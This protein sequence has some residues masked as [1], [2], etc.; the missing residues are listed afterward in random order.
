MASVRGV[1]SR[2]PPTWA[3]RETCSLYVAS[4]TAA[5]ANDTVYTGNSPSSSWKLVAGWSGLGGVE[6][7][8]V[9]SILVLP[10]F[11]AMPAATSAPPTWTPAGCRPASAAGRSTPASGPCASPTAPTGSTWTGCTPAATTPRPEHGHGSVLTAATAVLTGSPGPRDGGGRSDPA[12]CGDGQRP[13]GVRAPGGAVRERRRRPPHPR[14]GVRPRARRGPDRGRRQRRRP[15]LRR[16]R[17]GGRRPGHHQERR[18]AVLG[19]DGRGRGVP[20]PGGG[21]HQ[22]R[23]PPGRPPQGPG[24]LAG[25]PG[26]AGGHRGGQRHRAVRADHRL[27]GHGRGRRRGHRRRAGARAGGRQPGPPDRLGVPLRPHSAGDPGVSRLRPLLAVGHRR[28]PRGTTFGSRAR[29]V[30]RQD[31]HPAAVDRAAGGRRGAARVA[32]GGR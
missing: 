18:A 8:S 25:D 9:V 5:T 32:A 29:R 21:L 2:P 17:G 7:F 11:P 3:L 13:L 20:G 26:P 16:G 14:V 1:A 31:G 22:R 10:G 30:G 12:A 24:R 4:Q 23:H 15:R 27:L 19:G 6:W 28:Y